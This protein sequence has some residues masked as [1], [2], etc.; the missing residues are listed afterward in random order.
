[1][2]TPRRA[3][4]FFFRSQE[5]KGESQKAKAKRQ[6]AKGKSQKAKGKRQ[7][8]KGE[9]MESK[10]F[11]LLPFAFCL[12]ASACAE[13]PAPTITDD[14]GRSVVLPAKIERIIT[15]A[16]SLT[17]IAFATGAGAKIIATD[18]NS[19]DPAE[20]KKLPKV[21]GMQPDIEKIVALK[22][23]LVLASTE[24]NHP[25]LDPALAAANV[26]LFV[27]RTDR[28]HEVKHSIRRIGDL[29]DG[30]RTDEAIRALDEGVNAQRR[31]RTNPPRLLF[32]VWTDPLYVAGTSSFVDDL[33]V[34]TGARNVVELSGWPQYS[35]ET[36]VAR[37]PDI[38]LYP[39]G[40]VTAA[41]IDELLARAPGVNAKAVAVDQDVFQRPGPRLVEAAA[42]LN[43][44]LDQYEEER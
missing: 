15:L 35:L 6:K 39:E 23:D 14:L 21:G 17:E 33:F 25:N 26:P 10:A 12:L 41:Q 29:L 4:A 40:A 36:F 38:I 42:R 16:P 19:N 24:G 5:A 22:P 37:P 43:E 31:E 20:T 3:A 13:R 7:K 27:V 18:D 34:L 2:T 28:L 30:A 32:A 1:V 11:R 44:I 9:R 8:A